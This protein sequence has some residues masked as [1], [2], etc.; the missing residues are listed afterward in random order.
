MFVSLTA[1]CAT[2]RHVY[3]NQLS[4][5]PAALLQHDGV[6]GIQELYVVVWGV[7]L[8]VASS[9]KRTRR[10]A[11]QNSIS[12]IE[13]GAFDNLP[14]LRT[15]VLNDNQLTD[16]GVPVDVFQGA[17]NLRTVYVVRCG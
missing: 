15:L 12:T 2:G 17:P 4:S 5:I 8:P 11:Q 16:A 13:A 9:N 7:W 6:R 14:E 10:D 1:Q 3:K